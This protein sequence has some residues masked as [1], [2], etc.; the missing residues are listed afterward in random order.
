MK[1]IINL[2]LAGTLLFSLSSCFGDFALTKKVYKWNDSVVN[3]KMAK[4]LLFYGLNIIPVY[5]VAGTIDFFILN[6]LEFW[7]GSNPMAMAPGEIEE[8][9]MS[10]DGEDYTVIASQ[11]RFD[12][13]DAEGVLVKSVVFNP[14]SNT[15]SKLE[16]ATETPLVQ[17]I[18]IDGSD[19]A[20]VFKNGEAAASFDLSKQYSREEVSTKLH[21][22]SLSACK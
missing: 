17:Y 21:E 6:F 11:N 16:N 12:F 9:E 2:F 3:D 15:W 22:A 7:N 8:G 18:S 14:E 19:E 10:I 5:S 4:T 13:K 20:L 1:K